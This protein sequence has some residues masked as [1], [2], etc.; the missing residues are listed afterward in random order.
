MTNSIK[1]IINTFLFALFL[2]GDAARAIY[3]TYALYE[4]VSP[5]LTI[6]AASLLSF[7][8]TI[9]VNLIS[10]KKTDKNTCTNNVLRLY[11][12]LNV[13]TCISWVSGYLAI[14]Y[15]VPAVMSSFAV[16]IGPI[17]YLVF[18]K[19]TASIPEWCIAIGIL[20]ISA[21]FSGMNSVV[22]TLHSNNSYALL[23]GILLSLLCGISIFINTSLSRKLSQA[24][25][26]PVN[27]NTFRSLLVLTGAFIVCVWQHEFDI[28]FTQEYHLLIFSFWFVL[29]PQLA[30]QGCI[31]NLGTSI[32]TIGIA[33]SPL[34]SIFVQIVVFNIPISP[35]A[36][37]LLT[38]N[39]SLLIAL[40]V[41]QKQSL[42]S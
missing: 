28:S 15:I 5:A 14:Y 11:F 24:K 40:M 13:F 8:V 31:K 23:F 21:T 42:A 9:T 7:L 26:S 6:F 10:R 32:T 30:L 19:K 35:P 3:S 41:K 12:W 4:E 38:L 18:F 17:L 39:V 25:E 22:I 27:I 29:I 34:C 16:S 2:M 33:L 20:A 36:I 1:I 37:I